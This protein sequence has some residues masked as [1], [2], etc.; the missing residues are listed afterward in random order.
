[1]GCGYHRV[2]PANYLWKTL[3]TEADGGIASPS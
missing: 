3:P 2:R 1:M